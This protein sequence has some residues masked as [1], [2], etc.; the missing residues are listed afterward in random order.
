MPITTRDPAEMTGQERMQEIAAILAACIERLEKCNEKQCAKA[1]FER[2]S[3]GLPG[4][5]KHSCDHAENQ[6]GDA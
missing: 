4:R 1:T 5:R 2:G 6:S 3:T